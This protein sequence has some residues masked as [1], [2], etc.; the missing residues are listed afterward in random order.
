MI[1]CMSFVKP[2]MVI[3]FRAKSSGGLFLPSNEVAGG[4][5]MPEQKIQYARV[6]RSDTVHR[7]WV[8]QLQTSNADECVVNET[9]LA[10]IEDSSK[11]ICM[12]AYA[13]TP[14][15]SSDLEKLGK[16]ISLGHLILALRWCSQVSSEKEKLPEAASLS[17]TRLAELTS[18]LLGLELTVQ[19][20]ARIRQH[21]DEVESQIKVFADPLLD[22]YGEASEFGGVGSGFSGGGQRVGRLKSVLSGESWDAVRS[23]LQKYLSVALAELDKQRN[24]KVRTI[25][26]GSLFL[27]RSSSGSPF[28]GLGI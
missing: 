4:Q 7:K 12:F 26:P 2:G 15:T 14:E 16:S 22:L 25:E 11:R 3:A 27:R 17:I 23:Q 13:A 19:L 24:A 9:Q 10:G 21:P 5:S 28:R 18:A 1:D 8:V 20:E 6:L